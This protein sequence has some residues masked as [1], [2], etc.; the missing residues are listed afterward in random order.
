MGKELAARLTSL[1]Y[2][3]TVGVF[4]ETSRRV[5]EG[6][7][8]SVV[9]GDAAEGSF[10]LKLNGAYDAVFH[11][12]S[13]QR[14]GPEAYRRIFLLA[15]RWAQEVLPSSRLILFSSTSVYGQTD[16]SWVTEESPVCPQT[17]T[18]QILE[19]AEKM[20]LAG[21]G[22]VLRVAGIYGPGRTVLLTRLLESPAEIPGDPQRY[23]N[24]VHREDVVSAALLA[25]KLDP[26]IYNV[27]DDQPVRLREYYHWLCEQLGIP[28]PIF[29]PDNRPS[30]RGRTHKRVSN[31]KLKALGWELRY[32]SF[33][34][35]LEPELVMARDRIQNT[36]SKENSNAGNN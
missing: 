11:C 5:L 26:S 28:Q 22:V 29:R 36:M 15:T 27:V 2:E 14:G 21:N 3:V 7:G 25:L 20:V 34:E 19:E 10:W 32:P 13:S 30:K 33:R 17:E 31:A 23:V 35:G 9:H 1:G 4:S 24:Q 12:A 18:G 16:G 8:F 6:H